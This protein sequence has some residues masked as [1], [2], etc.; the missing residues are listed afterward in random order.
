[1]TTRT[2]QT[3]TRTPVRRRRDRAFM[4]A[5]RVL[6]GLAAV[7][8]GTAMTYFVFFASDEVAN[9]HT[10]WIDYPV[11]AVK[12]VTVLGLLAV[13]L[14]PGLS[15]ERRMRLGLQL[16]AVDVGFAL[17]KGTI[18]DEVGPALTFSTIDAVIALLLWL[19]ARTAVRD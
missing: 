4:T 9:W 7:V 15:P 18:Y 5:G 14:A 1:M 19:G 16:V 2:T 3:L 12:T 17:V 10:P 13:A 6:A 11:I 8:G